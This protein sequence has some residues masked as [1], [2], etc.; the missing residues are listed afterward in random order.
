MEG[1][2]SASAPDVNVDSSSQGRGRGGRRGRG[3]VGRG[4]DGGGGDQGSAG[5]EDDRASGA[6]LAATLLVGQYVAAAYNKEV[7]LAVVEGE[8]PDEEKPGYT[9]LKFLEKKGKNQYVWGKLDL[10]HTADEDIL[11]RVHAPVPVSNR[12]LGLTSDDFNLVKKI[13]NKMVY[14]HYSIW[15]FL[16]HLRQ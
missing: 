14:L 5:G 13:A 9:L 3:S 12:C 2:G 4:G 10:L 11:C 15:T 6:G 7:F 1:D 8:D 16:I